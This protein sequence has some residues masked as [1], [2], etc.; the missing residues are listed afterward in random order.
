MFCVQLS[1]ILHYFIAISR[2]R[3]D[4]K[5]KGERGKE[6]EKKGEMKEKGGWNVDCNQPCHLWGQSSRWRK[7]CLR[8]QNHKSPSVLQ[9]CSG[10]RVCGPER[11]SHQPIFTLRNRAVPDGHYRNRV[12]EC[13]QSAPWD[14]LIAI[15]PC[16]RSIEIK[17]NRVPVLLL[18]IWFT[19]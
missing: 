19:Q 13:H 17:V 9:R 14:A 4:E 16:N 8:R 2:Q 10:G 1:S 12:S 7:I 6:R 11:P 5:N 3:T 15:R 18:C